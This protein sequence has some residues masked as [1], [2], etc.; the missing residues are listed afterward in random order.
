MKYGRTI[1]QEEAKCLQG[2]LIELSDHF[3]AYSSLKKIISAIAQVLVL[4]AFE[5]TYPSSLLH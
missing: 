4:W 2:P 3:L 1:R 5:C